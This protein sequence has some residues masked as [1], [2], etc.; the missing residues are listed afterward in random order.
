MGD[1]TENIIKK[2]DKVFMTEKARLDSG[3]MEKIEFTVKEVLDKNHPA[4]IVLCCKEFGRDWVCFV[5]LH[6]V[7]LSTRV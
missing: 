5:A 7:Y 6:D 2:N 4:N 3:F 1:L